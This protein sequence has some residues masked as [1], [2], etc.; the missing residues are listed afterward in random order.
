MPTY[1]IYNN[2]TF[3]KADING[4]IIEAETLQYAN[5]EYKCKITDCIQPS[6]DKRIEHVHYGIGDDLLILDSE[7][8]EVI[9]VGS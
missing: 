5:G 7:I 4:Q 1:P 3:I 8:L 2:G 9:R 6:A